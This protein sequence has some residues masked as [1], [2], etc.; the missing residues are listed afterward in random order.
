MQGGSPSTDGGIR[1]VLDLRGV[2]E[3]QD[4][5]GGDQ[6]HNAWKQARSCPL[7]PADGLADCVPAKSVSAG[8]SS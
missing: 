6:A 8:V 7:A 4:Q 2:Q 1:G 3:V 5:G